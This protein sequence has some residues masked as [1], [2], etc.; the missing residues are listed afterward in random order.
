MLKT[1][2]VL[3]SFAVKKKGI[4]T[5]AF[6]FGVLSTGCSVIIPLFI[7]QFYNIALHS[8]SARGRI[9][10]SVFGH[11]ENIQTFFAFFAGFLS[12]RFV[13]NFFEKYFSGITAIVVI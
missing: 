13:F 5:G 3:R 8:G 10:E 12:I 1:L 11:I 4:I 9:F 7:G 6:V 2:D